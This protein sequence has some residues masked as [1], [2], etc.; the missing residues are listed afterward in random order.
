[1]RFIL[2]FRKESKRATN[3]SKIIIDKRETKNNAKEARETRVEAKRTKINAKASAK[4]NARATTIATTTTTIIANKKQLLR[5][6]KQFACMY[7]NFVFKITS[8]LSSY[9]L[10]FDNLRDY[11]NNALYN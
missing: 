3:A 10:L 9:L 11:A 5:L 8:I 7:I 4:A 6:H 1:V 2:R